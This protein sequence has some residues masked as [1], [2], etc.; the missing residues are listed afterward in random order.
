MQDSRLIQE[1]GRDSSC[2]LYCSRRPLCSELAPEGSGKSTL[3]NLI[4]CLDSPSQGK[5]RVNGQLVSELDDDELARIHN[6]EIG[7]VLQTFNLLARATSPMSNC[8]GSMPG[9]PPMN[10]WSVPKAPWPPWDGITHSA[11]IK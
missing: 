11:Q 6:K 10:A 4:G 8:H 2:F 9:C 3:M 5:Y 7:F 1:W